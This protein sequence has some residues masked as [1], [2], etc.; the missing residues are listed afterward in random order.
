MGKDFLWIEGVKTSLGP[1]TADMAECEYKSVG[2][3]KCV[4]PFCL[5]N[6]RNL[7]SN[8]PIHFTSHKSFH[9]AKNSN[10][11]GLS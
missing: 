3:D 10:V 5:L 9:G 6:M 1:S 11:R 8:I 4:E 7:C 2:F